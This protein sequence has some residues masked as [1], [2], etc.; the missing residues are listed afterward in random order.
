MKG[1]QNYIYFFSEINLQFWIENR[2]A[3][4]AAGRVYV[5]KHRSDE[6]NN[7]LTKTAIGTDSGSYKW[8]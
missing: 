6:E 4:A 5:M 1:L 2:D 3:D 7:L 8:I